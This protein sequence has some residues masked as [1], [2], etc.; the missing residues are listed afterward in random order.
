MRRRT[1]FLQLTLAAAILTLGSVM[2]A[3]VRTLAHGHPEMTAR[4][5]GT[6]GVS[7]ALGLTGAAVGASKRAGAPPEL[8][9]PEALALMP[10]APSVRAAG[11]WYNDYTLARSTYGLTG[12]MTISASSASDLRKYF[13]AMLP[14]RPGVETGVAALANGQ[15]LQR[16]GYDMLQL[17]GDIYSRSGDSYFCPPKGGGDFP[18]AVAVGNFDTALIKRD[19]VADSY[20]LTNTAVSGGALFIRPSL[21]NLDAH[22]SVTNAL[23]PTSRRLIAGG[24]PCG[25]ARVAQALDTGATTL[26]D[27]G[28]VVALAEALGRVQAAYVA[29]NV[30]PPPFALPPFPTPTEGHAGP[31]LHPFGLYAVAYQETR[32]GERYIVLGLDYA[33]RSDALSD[34]ATLSARLRRESLA[35]YGAPWRNL[36]DLTRASLTVDGSVLIARLRL[37]PATPPTLWQDVVIEHGLS[38]LSR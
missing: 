35:I 33:R 8:T 27:D 29:A 38:L 26:A 3:P 9:L 10:D 32:P 28:N 36:V 37:R 34:V 5:T 11:V 23:A 2:P 6:A 31:P 14:L 1:R 20:I 19:L 4:A 16:Y 18:L 7:P 17:G 24:R 12:T 25:V 13:Q 15:W 22:D 21:L 30:A